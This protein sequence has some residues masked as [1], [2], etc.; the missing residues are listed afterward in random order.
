MVEP[1]KAAR[2]WHTRAIVR[3]IETAPTGADP[4]RKDASIG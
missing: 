3:V 1:I 2:D 4:G